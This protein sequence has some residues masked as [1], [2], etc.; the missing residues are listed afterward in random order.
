MPSRELLQLNK[1]DV[2]SPRLPPCV[3]DHSEVD[4]SMF[5]QCRIHDGVSCRLQYMKSSVDVPLCPQ[6]YIYISLAS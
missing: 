6:V 5:L 3:R 4:S 1:H 2:V